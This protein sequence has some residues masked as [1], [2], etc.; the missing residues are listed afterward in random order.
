MHLLDTEHYE[1][2]SYHSEEVVLQNYEGFLG[3]EPNKR[4]QNYENFQVVL[5]RNDF[6]ILKSHL[7][8]N[9]VPPVQV[10]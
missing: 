9:F 5:L 6:R 8:E 10:T 3:M 1:T 7:G 2:P 4:L